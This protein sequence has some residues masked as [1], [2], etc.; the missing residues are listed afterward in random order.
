LKKILI[1]SYHSL[2]LDVVSSYRIKGYCDHLYKSGIIPTIITNRWEFDKNGNIKDH[3]KKDEIIYEEYS[4]YNIIRLPKPKYPLIRMKILSKLNS[5]LLWAKG[6][7][8]V[9]LINSYKVYKHFLIK[10]LQTHE[11]NFIV[12][13]YSPHYNLKLAYEMHKKFKIPYILDF[14]DLW[15]NRIA[16]H[17]YLPVFREKWED[18]LIRYFWKKWLSKALFFS[19]TSDH[20]KEIINEF[21]KTKGVVI[22]NGYEKIVSMTSDKTRDILTISYFGAIYPNQNISMFL[23]SIKSFINNKTPN[24][25]KLQFVGLKTRYRPSIIDELK[26]R[27]PDY[28]DIKPYLSKSQLFKQMLETDLFYF[29]AFDQIRGW[30]SVK[31]YDYLALQ[32]PIIICPGDNGEVDEIIYKTNAGKIFNGKEE[33]VQ[34][35]EKCYALKQAGKPIPYYG[36]KEE[37]LKFQREIQVN[38]FA[39]GINNLNY[40]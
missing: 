5:L 24:K 10:H 7:I 11:Y 20:W 14:R 32:K 21:S 1:I 17:N 6:N 28:I 34:Y 3:N 37:V 16:S 36:I 4:K 40:N 27:N 23:E 30:C 13:V 9:E 29:P 33:L 8:D 39:S 38:K 2:P 31:L 12:G 25:F 26:E 15:N 22:R 35:I 18:F 19:I